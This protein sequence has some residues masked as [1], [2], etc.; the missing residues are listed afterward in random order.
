V[1]DAQA[2]DE[3]LN[4]QFVREELC[5]NL[6][7]LLSDKATGPDG[8]SNRM[9]Q[10]GGDQFINLLFLHLS[11]IWRESIYPDQW[12]SSLMQ[13]LY[14]GD[15]KDREDLASYRGIFLS[16]AM[17]KLFEGIL[18]ARLQVFT[19]KA[20]TLTPSQQGSRPGRQWHD[21]IYGLLA[22][23]Q[24]QLQS[25]QKPTQGATPSLG[26]SYCWFVLWT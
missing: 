8:L 21:A 19:E 4:A 15:G 14:K 25:P 7:R 24:Q 5:S 20:D 23:V 26:A 10:L 12:A 6:R 11:D 3:D 13:P 1:A 2:P 16:N 9:L 18:E 17:L 22:A